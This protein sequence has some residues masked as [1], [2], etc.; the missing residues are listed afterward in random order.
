ME[1]M[2]YN[3]DEW[4]YLNYMFLVVITK[5]FLVKQLNPCIKPY[6]TQIPTRETLKKRD[7]QGWK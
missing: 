1:N 7:A 2:R 3:Y 5:P 4:I 6:S